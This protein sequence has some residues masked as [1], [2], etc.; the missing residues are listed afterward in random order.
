MC[1][2]AR[3]LLGKNVTA[4][5]NTQVAIAELLN[6]TFS[7]LSG[8]YQ[9]KL[10]NYFFSEFLVKI[11]NIRVSRLEVMRWYKKKI[12]ATQLIMIVEKINKHSNVRIYPKQ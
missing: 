4:A 1:T 10:G 9:R 8:L 2:F 3:Q 11:H 5:T 7:V 6:A 12:T